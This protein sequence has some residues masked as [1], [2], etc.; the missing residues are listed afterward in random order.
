MESIIWDSPAVFRSSYLLPS[1]VPCRIAD[2]GGLEATLTDPQWTFPNPTVVNSDF[3]EGDLCA[4]KLQKENLTP[5]RVWILFD[6]FR[7]AKFGP[8]L[9]SRHNLNRRIQRGC[10]KP[11][12]VRQVRSPKRYLIAVAL[13]GWYST[14]FNKASLG[15]LLQFYADMTFFL[16]QVIL[17]LLRS[18]HL[19]AALGCNKRAKRSKRPPFWPQAPF[20]QTY[21]GRFTVN[22]LIMYRYSTMF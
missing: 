10:S 21:F 16:S 20:I 13:H 4:G 11:T 22:P 14:V 8:L 19:C 1:C 5:I 2:T 6:N 7:S 3:Q 18:I 9:W 15:V 12:F 17:F